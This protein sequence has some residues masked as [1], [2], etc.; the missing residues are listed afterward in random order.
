MIKNV[1]YEIVEKLIYK[2]N[3]QIIIIDQMYFK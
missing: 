3:K 2:I 1:K